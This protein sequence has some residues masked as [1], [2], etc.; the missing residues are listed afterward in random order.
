MTAYG[1]YEGMQLPKSGK[2]VWLLPEGNL[3]YI[4]VTATEIEYD[5]PR[6]Y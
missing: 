3:E 1:E 2:A 6:Q 5:V 4:D